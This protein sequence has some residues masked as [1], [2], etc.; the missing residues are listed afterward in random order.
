M[1]V[2]VA[3]KVRTEQSNIS[4]MTE[5]VIHIDR[6]W[7]SYLLH[8]FGLLKHNLKD[9]QSLEEEFSAQGSL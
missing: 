9:L 5:F 7:G 6:V 4:S 8:H 3:V 1:V 2:V